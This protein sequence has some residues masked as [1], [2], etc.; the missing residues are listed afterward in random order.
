VSTVDPAPDDETLIA[1]CLARDES[2]WSTLIRRYRRLVYSVPF[3]YRMSSDEAGEIF[4]SVMVKLFK[5]LGTL[6]N[7]SGLASWLVVTTRRECISYRRSASRFSPMEEGAEDELPQD[8]EDVEQ[9]LHE[10]ACEHTLALAF[11]K[12]D[13]VCHGLL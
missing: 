12:M 7:R 10:I 2:A 4:Q 13:P 9:E 3:A 11:K 5:H 1:A 8:P 6:R